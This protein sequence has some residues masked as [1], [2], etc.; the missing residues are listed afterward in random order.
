M[1][2][3][4]YL[5]GAGIGIIFA[6]LVMTVSA[7][8]HKY[9]ISDE[10]IMKE[11]RKLGMVM[12]EELKDDNLLVNDLTDDT[13]TQVEETENIATEDNSDATSE[14]ESESQSTPVTPPVSE[15][16]PVSEAPPVSETPVVP[17]TPVDSETPVV[18]DTPVNSEEQDNTDAEYATIT[19]VRGDYARQVGEKLF[20]AGLV[21]DAEEFRKYMGN[22][23][24][25]QSI[26]AG[27][28]KIRKGAS[29]EEICKIV[30]GKNR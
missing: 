25:A 30:T 3:K 22:H 7:L 23:G 28:Y 29:Y 4:Y 21:A 5:R 9:N 19:I 12:K 24:Y 6:T 11:A 15:K 13:E 17:D 18:P 8:V 1:K 20:A 2:L 26:R 27:T 16:P 10:Y 14:S